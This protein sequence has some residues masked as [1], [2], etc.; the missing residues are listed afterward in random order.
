MTFRFL[1]LKNVSLNLLNISLTLKFVT[2]LVNPPWKC[3][4]YEPHI[5]LAV[6]EVEFR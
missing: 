1:I 2:I 3:F 6:W 4:Q 5:Q